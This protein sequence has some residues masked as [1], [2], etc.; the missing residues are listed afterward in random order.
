MTSA[1]LDTRFST[2]LTVKSM[3]IVIQITLI[4]TQKKY[5]SATAW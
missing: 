5:S 4:F 2:S 3:P 1:A